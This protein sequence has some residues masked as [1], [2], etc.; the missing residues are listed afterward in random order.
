MFTKQIRFYGKHAD[1]MRKYSKDKQGADA[2]HFTVI[3][4]SGEK[5]VIYLF[6]TI[7]QCYMVAAML[8]IINK[9]TAEVDTSKS[10][11][12][13]N[14]FADILIKNK[15]YLERIYHHLILS[16]KGN[17][18]A[19][20]IIKKAFTINKGEQDELEEKRLES[21]VRGGLEIIDEKFSSCQTYEDVANAIIDLNEDY[22][23]D[24]DES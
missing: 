4:N 18:T 1:I 7:L 23:V 16:E 9:R 20:G 21:Y 19:D 14:I 17:L 8:G 13:A 6:E 2:Q 5:K 24:L 11:S 22:R 3:N 12:T 10:T 15:G